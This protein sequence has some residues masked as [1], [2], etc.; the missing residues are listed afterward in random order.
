MGW[1]GFWEKENGLVWMDLGPNS[2]VETDSARSLLG[3]PLRFTP[4]PPCR[5]PPARRLLCATAATLQPAPTPGSTATG[6]N[7]GSLERDVHAAAEVVH[8]FP[9]FFFPFRVSRSRFL[10]ACSWSI[11]QCA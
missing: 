3:S 11:R 7:S 9:R 4:L 6:T 8:P 10:N 5:R 1:F 2:L